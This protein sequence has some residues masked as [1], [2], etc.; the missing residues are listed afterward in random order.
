MIVPRSM[1]F[2]FPTRKDVTEVGREMAKLGW[3]RLKKK[4]HDRKKWQNTEKKD[5]NK[6]V[7]VQ[8]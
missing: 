7:K 2:F 6:H 3:N 1:D 8:A 4:N 5:T